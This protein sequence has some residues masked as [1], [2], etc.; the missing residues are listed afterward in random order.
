MTD[1][2]ISAGQKIP[3]WLIKCTFRGDTEIAIR[4][5]MKS[6]F[7]VMG[8]STRDTILSLWF[9]LQ[10]DLTFAFEHLLLGISHRPRR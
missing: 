7:G 2:F 3:D 6:R 8:F 1:D 10:Q 9:S 4:S 5:G